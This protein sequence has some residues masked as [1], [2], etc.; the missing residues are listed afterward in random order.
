MK[1]LSPSSEEND[2][3]TEEGNHV[4]EQDKPEN[5][6]ILLHDGHLALWIGFA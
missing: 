5:P 1:G 3:Q 6:F 4:P 2:D